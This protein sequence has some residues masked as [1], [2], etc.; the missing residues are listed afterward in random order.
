MGNSTSCAWPDWSEHEISYPPDSFEYDGAGCMFVQDGQFIACV[1]S[2][3]YKSG[4]I[5]ISGFGGKREVG[6]NWIQ[7]AFRETV[8]EFFH[9]SLT[10][11]QDPAAFYNDLKRSI[12]PSRV[13]FQNKESFK[14][15][16]L[17]FGFSELVRFLRICKR[18]LKTSPVYA[19]FPT[20]IQAALMGRRP[21]AGAE[22][23]HLILWPLQFENAL[24]EFSMDLMV[25]IRHLERGVC[26]ISDDDELII[27]KESHA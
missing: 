27:E 24:M 16:T 11:V 22:I 6:E 23:F 20:S 13:L 26:L 10:A 14:Y 25:D 5:K 9:V 19:T 8:E 1:H 4:R 15:L 17:V 2:Q 21:V 18:H 3:T 12:A 7:T